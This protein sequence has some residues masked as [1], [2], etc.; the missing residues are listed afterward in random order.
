MLD[1]DEIDALCA[2]A[3]E[4]DLLVHTDEMYEKIIYDDHKHDSIAAEPGMWERTLTYNGFSKA[5]AMTGWRLGYVAG[6]KALIDEIAKV[7]SHSV[8]HATSFVQAGG[9]AAIDG[10][11]A[12]IGEMV[13]AWD[14]R[15]KAVA[16]GLNRIQGHRLRA[17]RRRVLRVCRHSR[18]R[19]GL[20]DHCRQT[21]AGSA[22]VALT[23]GD[24]FGSAGQG[25]VRSSFA[26]SDDLLAEAITRI[27]N[28]L[29]WRVTSLR[30]LI[31]SLL[32]RSDHEKGRASMAAIEKR[33][34]ELGLVLPAPARPIATYVRYVQ[35]GNLLFISGTGP[36][37]NAPKGKVGQDL[38][39][40]QAYEAARE[41]GLSIIATAKDAL[42][43]LDRVTR[44]V[45]VLGMVNGV[46][47]F[48]DQPKVING[49]SDLFVEVFGDKG[50][51]TRS[52]VGMG[53]LPGN[54]AVEIEC[55]L[56]VS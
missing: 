36:S 33:L 52:A 50:R 35:T 26:T 48:A 18:H 21:A 41:V 45:K 14:R 47:D 44:V 37:E 40:E 13:T 10:P 7:Q 54:I 12:F 34:E 22:H 11:Q 30:H 28:T 19:D 15:R 16:A 25:H 31:P 5:Y 1:R 32:T 49:C 2:F 46:P 4:H 51:H 43:D 23:P 42:G 6:P 27:G 56:E 17:R 55:T 3:K 20:D 53:S 24:A 8:T 29:G 38:T 9:V 39:V